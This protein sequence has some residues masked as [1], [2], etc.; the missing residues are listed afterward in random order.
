[1]RIRSSK[2]VNRSR[3]H[4][5]K[6][7]FLYNIYIHIFWFI[8]CRN[9][10]ID[11]G[12]S[13][14]TCSDCDCLVLQ[15]TH[16]PRLHFDVVTRYS[17]YV[18]HWQKETIIKDHN[19]RKG[20]EIMP[21]GPDSRIK[22]SHLWRLQQSMKSP[23]CWTSILQSDWALVTSFSRWLKAKVCQYRNGNPRH[24]RDCWK[25]LSSDV[26][27]LPFQTEPPLPGPGTPAQISAGIAAWWT[28]AGLPRSD[29]C[30]CDGS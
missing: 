5:I 18:K 3:R 12:K 28:P 10:T 26:F 2:P 13:W 16:W 21:G 6:L 11:K 20:I 1:M 19:H 8:N 14:P 22:Q 4:R 7:Y 30:V 24:R 27:S 15:A 25:S 29:S 9:I 23:R 17:R